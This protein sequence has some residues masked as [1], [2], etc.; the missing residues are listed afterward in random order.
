MWQLHLFPY[1]NE[2]FFV[3]FL[4]WIECYAYFVWCPKLSIHRQTVMKETKVEFVSVIVLNRVNSAILVVQNL[5]N[6]ISVVFL[7]LEN[8]V[9]LFA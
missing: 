2:L 5:A 3:P 4:C 1:D 6:S 8:F 9:A 7:D